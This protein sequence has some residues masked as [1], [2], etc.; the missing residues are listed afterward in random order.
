M[1]KNRVF[2]ITLTLMAILIAG[3]LLFSCARKKPGGGEGPPDAGQNSQ[4][5]NFDQAEKDLKEALRKNPDDPDKLLDLAGIETMKGNFEE[6]SKYLS[7]LASR[8]LPPDRKTAV[9]SMLAETGETDRA[10]EICRKVIEGNETFSL[11][12]Y[13]TCA[14]VFTKKYFLDLQTTGRSDPRYLEE[15]ETAL[16]KVD[17]KNINESDPLL[18]RGFT[19]FMLGD[20]PKADH[21]FTN[22]ETSLDFS[23]MPPD[24]IF[25]LRPF[26]SMMGLCALS[27]GDK[28]SAEKN[29][30][31]A[32]TIIDQVKSQEVATFFSGD[33]RLLLAMDVFLGKRLTTGKLSE[34]KNKLQAPPGIKGPPGPD[35]RAFVYDLVSLREKGDIKGAEAL[36]EKFRK[37]ISRSRV[38]V[39]GYYG[40]YLTLHAKPFFDTITALYMGDFYAEKG[41]TAESRRS[42]EEALKIEPWNRAI[43]QKLNRR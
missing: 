7:L 35:M 33:E 4:G 22:F 25:L 39:M 10:L 32:L 18:I 13:I 28:A 29:L 16:K 1:K 24:R 30:N 17:E 20:M 2:S 38:P 15:A 40:P 3:S 12:L 37:E 21:F 34:I 36:L 9:I 11:P 31:K 5:Q 8:N 23:N 14:Q 42:Y 19:A 27:R 43:L 26:Y 41:M 6:G